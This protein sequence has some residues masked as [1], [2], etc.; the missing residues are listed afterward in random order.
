MKGPWLV[1]VV[2]GLSLSIVGFTIAWQAEELEPS[3]LF[4]VRVGYAVSSKRVWTRVNRLM[5]L[6]LGIGGLAVVPVGLLWGLAAEVIA[7]ALLAL[8]STI[9]A[10]EYSRRLAEIESLREPPKA[11]PAEAVAPLGAA[12]R[13]LVASSLAASVAAAIYASVLLAGEGIGEAGVALWVLVGMDA[14]LSY[15]ALLRPEAYSLPWLGEYYRVMAVLI[16]VSLSLDTIAVSLIVVGAT[17]LGL[18]LLA[19]STGLVALAAAV[20]LRRYSARSR[21]Q[22]GAAAG[23]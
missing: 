14:Y 3:P 19:L 9:A 12:A 16:P 20:S 1:E 7:L 8:A 18:G 5:G 4:G 11:G 21:G 23:I 10:I 22:A 13:V 6:L 17:R 15:L 2:L